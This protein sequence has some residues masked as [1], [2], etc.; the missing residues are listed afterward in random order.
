M[1]SVLR[2]HLADVPVYLA[3]SS[4]RRQDILKNVSFPFEVRP[5]GFPE[6]LDKSSFQFPYQYAEENAVSKA[7]DVAAN[8]ERGVIIGADTVVVHSNRILEKPKDTADAETM[9]SRLSGTTHQVVTG[10]SLVLKGVP[11]VEETKKTFHVTTT[12]QF[13]ALSQE[14]IKSYVETGEPM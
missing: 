6:T 8:I 2:K 12:V 4:P 3:S 13:A 9:L 10:V 1:I 14:V 7:L 5:S 11:G